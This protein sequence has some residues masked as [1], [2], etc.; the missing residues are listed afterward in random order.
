MAEA[1]RHLYVVHDRI[2]DENGEVVS[3]ERLLHDLQAAETQVRML[4]R[5]RAGQQLKIAALERDK[6]KEREKHPLKEKIER[7]HSYWQR[8]CNHPRAGLDDETFFKIA[9]LME[10]KVKPRSDEREFSYP[11]DFKLAI[12]G[13]WFD[14]W[15]KTQKNGRRVRHDELSRVFKNAD[16]MREYIGKAPVREVRD[17]APQTA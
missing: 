2:A 6:A 16:S 17:N 4:E 5:E 13:V 14:P 8:R 15:I 10:L 12:D 7:V 3:P 1:A 11:D 9:E